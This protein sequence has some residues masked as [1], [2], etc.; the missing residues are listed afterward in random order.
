MAYKDLIKKREYQKRYYQINKERI[1]IRNKKWYQMNFEKMQVYRKKWRKIHAK[2]FKI[3]IKKYNKENYAYIQNRVKKYN[4]KHAKEIS[5]QKRNYY[6]RNKGKI[7][8]RN[9]EWKYKQLKTNIN[10]YLQNLLRLRILKVLKR[11]SLKKVER[12]HNLLGITIPKARQCLEFQFKPGMTWRNHGEWHIDH[13]KPLSSFDLTNSEEQK[14]AFHYTNLQPLWA[15]EN[16][17]KH[18]KILV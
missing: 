17:K 10:Y 1:K 16:M 4:Q 13:I 8:L 12:T 6:Q 15:G 9:K 3:Y 2:E 11:Q 7:N 5:L 18:T 14:K